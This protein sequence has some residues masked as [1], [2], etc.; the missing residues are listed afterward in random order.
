MQNEETHLPA[1]MDAWNHIRDL[2]LA[3][4]MYFGAGASAS[5]LQQDQNFRLTLAREYNLIAPGIEM[6]FGV[7]QPRQGAYDFTASDYLVSFAEA[8]QMAVH[9]HVLCWHIELPAWVFEPPV[10]REGLINILRTHIYTL[11]GRYRGRIACWDV[12]NEALEKDGTLTP[13]L[14]QR[15]IGPEYLD[16]AFQWA[17]EIDPAA[18]LFYNDFGCEG[19]CAKADGLYDLVRGMLDRGV[20]IH[21][22][23]LQAHLSLDDAPTAEDLAFNIARLGHL[24]LEVQITELDVQT[25]KKGSKEERL[26][27]QADLYR[28]IARVAVEAPN[29]SGIITWG[30]SDCHSWLG[31]FDGPDDVG[32]LPWDRSYGPKPALLAMKQ[33]FVEAAPVVRTTPCVL[34]PRTPMAASLT[35]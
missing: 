9:G 30:I 4:G 26:V 27:R 6:K 32:P 5:Q 23:G 7:C 3:R 31:A 2:A 35:V 24:G 19:R 11:A 33:A 8:Q 17:H 25:G 10:T 21:G 13:T 29:C 1:W 18:R 28:A 34:P 12:V 20:P 14:W 22:V 15:Q 16:L